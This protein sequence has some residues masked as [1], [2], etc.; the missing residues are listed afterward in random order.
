M[1]DRPDLAELLESVRQFI[2]NE[3]VPVAPDPRLKFRARV[4]ANVLAVAAR[5][6]VL[7][8]PLLS[9]ELKRLERIL[10]EPPAA[11]TDPVALRA[12]VERLTRDLAQRIR[13]GSIDASPGT[14]AWEHLRLTAIEKL[15]IANPGCLR[16]I[17]GEGPA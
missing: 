9:R 12:K 2:E 8:S 1:Q 13:T 14:K 7:E 17:K 3:L 10:G 4:A 11:G 16:R 15:E 6:R 5:E